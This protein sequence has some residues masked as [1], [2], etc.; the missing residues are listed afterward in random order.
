MRNNRRAVVYR[1]FTRR[2]L[3]PAW[4]ERFGQIKLKPVRILFFRIEFDL[5]TIEVLQD[6]FEA[7]CVE[8]GVGPNALRHEAVLVH[9]NEY[10]RENKGH[11]WPGGP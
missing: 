1:F 8:V 3:F 10:E 4:F 7:L 11:P 2:L 6:E 9:G 5:F